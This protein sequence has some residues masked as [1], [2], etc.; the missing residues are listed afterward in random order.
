MQQLRPDTACLR[1]RRPHTL[2]GDLMCKLGFV[3]WVAILA[4]ISGCS[5]MSKPGF[6][7]QSVDDTQLIAELERLFATGNEITDYY[8][9][10][11]TPVAQRTTKRNEIVGGRMTLMDLHYNRFLQRISLNKQTLDTVTDIIE[12]GVNLAIPLVGGAGTKDILGVVSAGITGTKLTI[13]KNFFFEKTVPVLVS[14]MNAQRKQARVPIMEGLGRPAGE[15][16]LEQALVDLNNYYFAGTFIGALQSI[17][18]QAGETEKAADKELK[19]IVEA[20]YASTDRDLRD[21]INNWLSS[22]PAN[23]K[24][25]NSWLQKRVPPITTIAEIWVDDEKTSRRALQSAIE[26]F[27][28]PK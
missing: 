15:Y 20:R 26:A 13:D 9:A 22:D 8:D 7:D 12:L 27:K 11:K 10:N 21:R 17:Q 16:P 24:A 14:E 4:L 19:S 5:G 23:V 1:K 28:I 6:P 3:V 18:A 2:W 25:L